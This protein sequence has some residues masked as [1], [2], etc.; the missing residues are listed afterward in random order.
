[1]DAIHNNT[2]IIASCSSLA[3]DDRSK[4]KR[5]EG[6]TNA[7]NESETD[8]ERSDHGTMSHL[9]LIPGPIGLL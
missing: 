9:V 6:G 5:I 2:C 8:E 4:E 7:E 3:R 1:M